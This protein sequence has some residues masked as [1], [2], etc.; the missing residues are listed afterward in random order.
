MSYTRIELRKLVKSPYVLLGTCV[1]LG[2]AA[3]LYTGFFLKG[4]DISPLE[5]CSMAIGNLTNLG[6]FQLTVVIA[7]SA[8][9]ASEYGY[10]TLRYLMM[11]P[12]SVERIFAA[13]GFACV[14]YVCMTAGFLLIFSLAAGYAAWEPAPLTGA[15]GSVLTAPFLRIGLFYG[16]NVLNQSFLMA[17]ALLCAVLVRNHT[18]AMLSAYAIYVLM[19]IFVPEAAAEY[20]PK[21]AID[22]KPYLTAETP[23]YGELFAVSGVS[24]LYAGGLTA[25]AAV[26]YA[27]GRKE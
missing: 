19:L 13:K 21:A 9:F 3:V 18:T 1:S 14:L 20:T 24:L 4:T 16:M 11:R 17:L 8:A 2:T 12:V 22:L 10:G 26:T 7:A 25:V 15:D 23:R 5:F 6:V 27:A